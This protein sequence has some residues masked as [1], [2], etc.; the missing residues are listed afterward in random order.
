MMEWQ[1]ALGPGPS[2]HNLARLEN[3][4]EAAESGEEDRGQN[5][6]RLER[7]PKASGGFLLLK[8]R[9]SWWLGQR[10]DVV[11]SELWKVG[12]P[13][14]QEQGVRA[15][16]WSAGQLREWKRLPL[17][18]RDPSPTPGARWI[19]ALL[20]PGRGHPSSTAGGGPGQKQ[21]GTG[22]P[23]GRGCVPERNPGSSG[24]HSNSSQER[25]GTP[26]LLVDK[27]G[28]IGKDKTTYD[29]KDEGLHK[30]GCCVLRSARY[31]A[32]LFPCKT[33]WPFG[34]IAER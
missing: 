4:A 8:R 33:S 32:K 6:V 1:T 10:K 15:G 22:G 5:L 18:P 12:W 20:A 29:P 24:D 26:F 14:Q 19:S 28:V 3:Q 34:K 17:A 16:H 9:T 31:C 27:K 23:R 13:R 25:P 30:E 2:S 11:R 21:G 7:K